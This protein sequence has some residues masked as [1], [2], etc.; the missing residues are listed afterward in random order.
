MVES[1]IA[2][3]RHPRA[4]VDDPSKFLD[5]L[6]SLDGMADKENE[7]IITA[8]HK[9][10]PRTSDAIGG[11]FELAGSKKRGPMASVLETIIKTVLA[12]QLLDN[13]TRKKVFINLYSAVGI[14]ELPF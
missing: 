11:M 13:K 8:L 3:A 7:R 4:D 12:E 10:C 9:Y 6:D 5:F 1:L 2:I 14:E